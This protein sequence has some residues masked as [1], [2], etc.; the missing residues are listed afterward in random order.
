M[1]KLN[2]F[3]NELGEAK[4]RLSILEKGSRYRMVK[5]AAGRLIFLPFI[6]SGSINYDLIRKNIRTY[7]KTTSDLDFSEMISKNKILIHVR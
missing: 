2:N 6:T 7:Y 5:L 3:N 4:A 1:H